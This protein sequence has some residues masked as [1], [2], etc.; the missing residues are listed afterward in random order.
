MYFGSKY[1]GVSVTIYTY[2]CFHDAGVVV[3]HSIAFFV[4]ELIY[5]FVYSVY[6]LVPSLTLRSPTQSYISI[7][8]VSF[9]HSFSD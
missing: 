7:D 9:I 6:E 2:F 4:H 5:I 1:L 8:L 3:D